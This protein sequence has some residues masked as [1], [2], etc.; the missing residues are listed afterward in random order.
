MPLTIDENNL[1]NGVLTLV[2]T[3]VEVIQEALEGQALRR[4]EGGDLT[5]DEQERL[6]QALL[7]LDEALESIKADHGLGA[8]VADLRRGLDDVV[9]DVV[10]RLVNPV[11]GVD[12]EGGG[13]PRAAT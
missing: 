7:D 11:L 8:S 6:G 5:A 10:D 9:G 13:L 12:P 1:K 4:I 2:V 3:L